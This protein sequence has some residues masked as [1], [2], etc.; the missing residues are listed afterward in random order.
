MALNDIQIVVTGLP[1]CGKTGVV[2]SLVEQFGCQAINHEALTEAHNGVLDWDGFF[3]IAASVQQMDRQ[4]WCVIDA[5]STLEDEPDWVAEALAEKL[6]IADAVVFSFVENAS[7]Q[8]QSWWNRWLAEQVEVLSRETIPV[9]RC[10][11]QQFPQGFDGFNVESKHKTSM[12]GFETPQRY[13]FEVGSVML[14]HLLMGLDNSRRN[15]GMKIVRTEGVLETFEFDNLIVLQGT[16]Y[17]LDTFAADEVA[18]PGWLKISGYDLDRE[19]LKQ[20]ID[21]SRL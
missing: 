8:Q 21:A 10:F 18:E 19:W 5:R 14:D 7:L 16:P 15:L 11:Y 13:E 3:P 17:R 6:K 20:L 12:N 9:V 1:G 2:N 4:I